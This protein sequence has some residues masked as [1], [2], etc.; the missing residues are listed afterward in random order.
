MATY[1]LIRREPGYGCSRCRK[2]SAAALVS[3]APTRLL[4]YEV[5]AT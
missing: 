4:A 5:N 3:L 1:D 2:V